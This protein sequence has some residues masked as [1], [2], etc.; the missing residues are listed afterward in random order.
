VKALSRRLAEFVNAGLFLLA[1]SNAAR[2]LLLGSTLCAW[3]FLSD[4]YFAPWPWWMDRFAFLVLTTAVLWFAIRLPALSRAP[5]FDPL[6]DSGR[7]LEL[8]PANWC[9][10][11]D[12]IASQGGT[13]WAAYWHW[14]SARIR[15]LGLNHKPVCAGR[16]RTCWWFHPSAISQWMA[17]ACLPALWI[18]LV[19]APLHTNVMEKIAAAADPHPQVIYYV[20]CSGQLRSPSLSGNR[21][22]FVRKQVD[23]ALD[24]GSSVYRR[25]GQCAFLPQGTMTVSS[26]PFPRVYRRLEANCRERCDL[27][28][29]NRGEDL[30][31]LQVPVV[32]GL[33][34][35]NWIQT[36]P[37][38]SLGMSVSLL[39]QDGSTL[40]KVTIEP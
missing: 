37:E 27:L 21:T 34:S 22:S 3:W 2:L 15:H 25:T 19:L 5:D 30:L 1:A 18:F 24:S 17:L 40:D 39:R 32:A 28:P 14:Y 16:L 38:P 33:A 10:I 12:A 29:P 4:Y 6:C 26:T 11:L 9:A 31:F 13:L 23:E 7:E 35:F 20:G 36:T 8:T